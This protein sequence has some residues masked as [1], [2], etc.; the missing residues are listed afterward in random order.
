M[1]F[2]NPETGTRFN[3]S[4][5]ELPFEAFL[6]EKRF[7]INLFGEIPRSSQCY[8]DGELYTDTHICEIDLQHGVTR[9]GGRDVNVEFFTD[10]GM[11]ERLKLVYKHGSKCE[12]QGEEN[13]LQ[14]NISFDCD[15]LHEKSLELISESNC[16]IEIRWAGLAG[17]PVCDLAADY[18][19]F[20]FLFSSFSPFFFLFFYFL[21]FPFVVFF[22]IQ[23]QFAEGINS[24][25]KWCPL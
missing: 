8:I 17:C 3:L 12:N 25:C 23:V 5:Y 19:V 15:V 2:E 22:L 4:V 18:D 24:L 13:E 14:T 1:V 20:L 21:H 7:E 11:N 6:N 16:E 9:D 10:A